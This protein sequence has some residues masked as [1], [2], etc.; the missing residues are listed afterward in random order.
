MAAPRP[1]P[2]NGTE[3]IWSRDLSV[4]IFPKIWI[5]DLPTG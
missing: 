5:K 2:K 1:F 3:R 4:K